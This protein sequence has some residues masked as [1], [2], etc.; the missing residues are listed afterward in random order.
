MLL[1]V[2]CVI[3]FAMI[4]NMSGVFQGSFGG[5]FT[6]AQVGYAG[7][8]ASDVGREVLSFRPH[9]AGGDLVLLHAIG[10]HG[11]VLLGLPALLLAGAA[12]PESGRLLRIRLLTGSVTVGLLVLAQHALRQ[13]PWDTLA[14]WEYAAATL[15]AVGYLGT[16]VEVIVRG[17]RQPALR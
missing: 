17:V 5:G 1:L 15:A 13:Q 12:L 14:P 9:T 3:G 11:L 8:P 10:V 4:S 7:P 16:L 2:G 6:R